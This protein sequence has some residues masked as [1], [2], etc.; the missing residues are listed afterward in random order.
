MTVQRVRELE[1]RFKPVRLPLPVQREV[2]SPRDAAHIAQQLLGESLV[3]KAIS[4]YLNNGRRLIGVHTVSVGTIDSTLVL[5]RDVLLPALMS[6]ARSVIVA[7][8]HPSGDP[9][10]SPDDFEVTRR[11][12]AAGELLGVTV[13]DSLIIGESGR[14]F[15]F[16]ESGVM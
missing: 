16:R 15:S 4:L 14:Y 1:I 5:P 13:D 7:H 12:Y 6:G 3:E 9:T 10:P 11:L 8:N 2:L